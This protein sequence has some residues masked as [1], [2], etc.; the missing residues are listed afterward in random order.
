MQVCVVILLRIET[1][2]AVMTALHNV[3]RNIIQMNARAAGH[4]SCYQKYVSLAPLAAQ[5][6]EFLPEA[7]RTEWSHVRTKKQYS[8]RCLIIPPALK[9]AALWIPRIVQ[10]PDRIDEWLLVPTHTIVGIIQN[11]TSLT[12]LPPWIYGEDGFVV[13]LRTVDYFLNPITV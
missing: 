2:F 4:G 6:A 11:N 5:T 7:L 8:L 9:P 12:F 3:Q 13:L 1:S 10:L